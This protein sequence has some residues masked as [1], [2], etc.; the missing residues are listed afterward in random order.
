MELREKAADFTLKGI[1]KDGKEFEFTLS[2]YI[3]KPVVLFFYAKD[4]GS[5]CTLE[6]EDFSDYFSNLSDVVEVA[7]I[8]MDDLESH[9]EFM[10]TY[11]IK[12]PLLS[13]PDALVVSAYGICEA[14]DLEHKE[15]VRS[16]FLIDKEGKIAAMWKDVEVNGHAE[17]VLME[18][19]GCE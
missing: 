13:D 4:R 18:L 17:E 10:E 8:S 12:I 3:G 9:R 2:N 5:K 16:T 19:R 14:T 7:G 15:F 11:D 1:N 6:I